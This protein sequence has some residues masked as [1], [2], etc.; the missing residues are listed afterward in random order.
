[1]SAQQA[2]D[3][4]LSRHVQQGPAGC[5]CAVAQNGEILYEGYYG[6]ANLEQ[7][8]PITADTIYRQ[9]SSTKVVICTAA[10]MLYERGKFLLNDPIYAY[11]PEWRN[12][13]VAEEQPDGTYLIRPVKR[14]IQVR[15]CFTMSMGI[16]YGGEDYTHRMMRRCGTSCRLPLEIIPCGMIFGPWRRYRYALTPEAAGCTALAMSWWPA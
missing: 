12:T 2:M 13:Q 9:F 16:G 1:M 14:P 11:F 15:D 3:A 4:F 10:M 7:K 5:G 6:Y 8:T